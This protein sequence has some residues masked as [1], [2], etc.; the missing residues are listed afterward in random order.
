MLHFSILDNP[1]PTP[2]FASSLHFS[3]PLTLLAILL[4]KSLIRS[5]FC[6]FEY[7]PRDIYS[8]PGLVLGHWALDSGHA[9]YHWHLDTMCN[10]VLVKP[11]TGK[12]HCLLLY[13]IQIR[14]F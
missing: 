6:A 12:K 1:Y 10:G 7:R 11:D 2:R 14:P 5:A 4:S 9:S 13:G 3:W 8:I